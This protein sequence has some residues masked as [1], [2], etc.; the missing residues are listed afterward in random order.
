ME[1]MLGDDIQSRQCRDRTNIRQIKRVQQ[2]VSPKTLRGPLLDRVAQNAQRVFLGQIRKK[3]LRANKTI[4]AMHSVLFTD[5]YRTNSQPKEGCDP[6]D[7][8]K[9][10][11]TTF[12]RHSQRTCLLS[13]GY[14]SRYS[15]SNPQTNYYAQQLTTHFSKR[16]AT[17]VGYS[18]RR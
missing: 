15:F 8:S 12:L 14:G 3:G 17:K 11:T 16:D 13:C 5:K 1:L 18:Q 6:D 9:L 4:A 10:N 7:R 2:T